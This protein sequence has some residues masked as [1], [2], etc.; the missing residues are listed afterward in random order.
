MTNHK[1]GVPQIAAASP[2]LSTSYRLIRDRVCRL[3]KSEISF[4]KTPHSRFSIRTAS[5]IHSLKKYF[6]STFC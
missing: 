5:F 2:Y 6:L 1:V 4:P 3:C